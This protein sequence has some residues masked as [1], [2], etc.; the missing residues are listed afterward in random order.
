MGITNFNKWIREKYP[1]V[2]MQN[3]YEHSFEHL[4]VDLNFVLHMCINNTKTIK[5]LIGKVMSYIVYVL[6]NVEITKSITFVTDGAGPLAKVMLQKIRRLAM[7]KCDIGNCLTPLILTPGTP[8]MKSL[9]EILKPKLLALGE[10]YNLKI[11]TILVGPDEAEMKIISYLSK[12]EENREKH[13]ILSNDADVV[14]MVA[15]LQKKNI[16]VLQKTLKFSIFDVNELLE[17]HFIN[18]KPKNMGYDFAMVSILMGNDYLPHMAFVKFD[19]IWNAYFNTLKIFGEGFINDKIEIDLKFLK[20]FL[21]EYLLLAPKSLSLKLT[22]EE[23]EKTDYDNYLE[24]LIWCLTSYTKGEC[25]DYDFICNRNKTIHPLGLL[26]IIEKMEK[27]EINKEMNKQ[28]LEDDIYAALVIPK[29]GMEM[30]EKKYHKAIMGKLYYMY[31]MEDCEECKLL[32]KNIS[33]T[34]KYYRFILD[35]DGICDKSDELKY[36]I[37]EISIK[38]KLHKKKHKT[39]CVDDLKYAIK[40]FTKIKSKKSNENIYKFK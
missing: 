9:D 16:Y 34:N 10:E 23:I 21:R 6:K 3:K 13:I 29:I 28:S 8:F 39:I 25:I 12:L 35:T 33:E 22:L 19:R 24:G 20:T 18:K 1:N 11:K 7:V 14:V 5:G 26:Y 36:K 31:E 4:Y 2:F 27:I 37:T 15:S 38:T 40:C 30:I 32:Y 17:E